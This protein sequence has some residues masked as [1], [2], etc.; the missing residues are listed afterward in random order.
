MKKWIINISIIII[1][2]AVGLYLANEIFLYLAKNK[3]IKQ[4]QEV[5]SS[6]KKSVPITNEG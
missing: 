6:E 2:S 5:N 3:L 4:E 1:S